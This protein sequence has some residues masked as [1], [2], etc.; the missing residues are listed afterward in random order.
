KYYWAIDAR[1]HNKDEL[2]DAVDKLARAG[3]INSPAYWK[4]GKGYSDANVVSLIKKA[5]S[6]SKPDELTLA[7]CKL[8][9]AGIIDSPDYWAAG[10][11][12]SSENVVALI[13][14]LAGLC[15]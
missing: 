10:K 6:L 15:K 5:A 4:Q 7:C 9:A 1:E 12:Y 2:A 13:K 8:A 14:K 11:G 3:V